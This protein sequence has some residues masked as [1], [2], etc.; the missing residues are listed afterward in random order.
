VAFRLKEAE[1]FNRRVLLQFLAA[2]FACLFLA[3][4]VVAQSTPD[5]TALLS[6]AIAAAGG[7]ATIEGVRDFIAHGTVTQFRSSTQTEVGQITIKGRGDGQLRIDSVLQDGK[8]TSQA[9]TNGGGQFKDFTGKLRNISFPNAVNAG[10]LTLP[11]LRLVAA[12][13]DSSVELS[14]VGLQSIKG[15]SFHQV[16]VIRHFPKEMDPKDL[17]SSLRTAD[18]YLNSTD[19][20]ITGVVDHVHPERASIGITNHGKVV[21]RDIP[22]ALYYSDFRPVNGVLVPFAITTEIAHQRLWSVQLTDVT[23]NVGL[24]DS[25]FTL[26]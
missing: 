4:Q 25:D 12:L 22:R 18:F 3:A 8:T 2:I 20:K 23:F 14:Y 26:Q 5:P 13:D 19:L 24:T 15:T 10:W 1:I 6:Q 17:L 7:K 21:T 9:I 16:R 11:Y